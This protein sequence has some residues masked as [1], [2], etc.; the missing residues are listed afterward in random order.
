MALS[1]VLVKQVIIKSDGDVFHDLFGNRPYHISEMT[2]DFIKGVDLH[3]GEWGIVGS[4]SVWNFTHDGK[5]KVAK[6]V[7]EEIDKEKKLVRYK[8]IGGEI[9]EAYK[10]FFVTIHVDTKGE[11][12]VVTWT[13]HYEKL[14]ESVDDP[15]SLMDLCLRITKD[16]E[17]HHLA[18]SN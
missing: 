16:I 2:P 10:S 17:N 15:N 3:D 8:V 7:I 18:K 4:V 9:L 11:E 5:E 13:F 14:N 12:N 6:Q 1:G